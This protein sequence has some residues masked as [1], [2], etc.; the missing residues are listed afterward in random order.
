MV[1]PRFLAACLLV[2]VALHTSAQE[3]SPAG[4]VRAARGQIGKTVKYDPAYRTLAY[5]N[6]DLAMEVGVCT[7]VVIRAL[8]ASLGMDL[9]RLVHEDMNRAFA[10]YP[11]N[12]GLNRPDRNIDHRRVPNLRT[13]F[14][15]SGWALPV[16]RSA[17]DYRPGDL[18]T[19]TV[20]PNL[21]HI[22]IVSDRTTADGRPLVIHNIGAGTQEED[23]LFEFP[24][25]GH[26]RVRTMPPTN[27]AGGRS[28]PRYP[29]P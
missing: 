4:I 9:Q 14:K 22:M 15:R 8:R 27:D 12:W 16:T 6:G 25:T 10:E 11:R 28:Q 1:R 19:C 3:S 13:F 26:Y 2:F 23:R 21:P 20:P 5:P 7:D 29:G 17:R 18:V 24:I